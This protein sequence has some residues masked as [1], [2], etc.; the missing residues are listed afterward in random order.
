MLPCC[1]SDQLR[2]SCQESGP[3]QIAAALCDTLCSPQML[4]ASALEAHN[5]LSSGPTLMLWAS[6]S[7]CMR[8]TSPVDAKCKMSVIAARRSSSA[9][10]SVAFKFAL[11]SLKGLP[12]CFASSFC[13]S[14][15]LPMTASC[16]TCKQLELLR[17]CAHSL[18]SVSQQLYIGEFCMHSFLERSASSPLYTPAAQGY[19][20]TTMG[21]CVG[22]SHPQAFVR[23]GPQDWEHS[24]SAAANP[25][26]PVV[27]PQQ[28]GACS[29]QHTS[30]PP[31]LAPLCAHGML[32]LRFLRCSHTCDADSGR[33]F[34]HPMSPYTC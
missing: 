30:D 23:S 22:N 12:P 34:W 32:L 33:Q 18:S 13:T 27:P 4:H 10:A 26:P 3:P 28:Q 8:R 31:A 17:D 24:Y 15:C 16:T 21:H 7:T 19:S 29:T 5:L 6:H 14:S 1:H 2:G 20:C 9:C 25:L 11:S